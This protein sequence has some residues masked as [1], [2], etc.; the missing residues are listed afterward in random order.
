MNFA[1]PPRIRRRTDNR[2][3]HWRIRR[4]KD[5]RLTSF[6]SLANSSTDR[7][8]FNS[9]EFV[10]GQTIVQ[11][12]GE[13]VD[14]KTFVQLSTNRQSFNSLANSSTERQSFNSLANSS[15]DRQSFNSRANSWTDRQCSSR[16]FGPYPFSSETLLPLLEWIEVGEM[17]DNSFNCTLRCI[18]SSHNYSSF[19]VVVGRTTLPSVHPI[20]PLLRSC[21]PRQTLPSATITLTNRYRAVILRQQL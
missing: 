10:D 4:R 17:T 1:H 5:N 7:H 3:T 20:R 21:P 13:F 19:I 8:S 16:L 15:T 18:F 11:L 9:G 14:G 12:T 2:S 6:N